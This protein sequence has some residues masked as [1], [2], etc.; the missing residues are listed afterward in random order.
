[1]VACAARVLHPC[2]F[3]NCAKNVR[4]SYPPSHNGR[5]EV[6][7]LHPSRVA[8]NVK[9]G[10][11]LEFLTVKSP[12]TKKR[13]SFDVAPNCVVIRFVLLLRFE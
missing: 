10:W 11:I 1:M 12:Y 9:D 3:T 5:R 6:A 2:K 13:H 7:R 4:G 8:P